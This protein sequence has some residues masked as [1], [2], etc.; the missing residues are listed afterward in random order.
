[1]LENLEFYFVQNILIYIK[2]NIL[3]N[4]QIQKNSC[5]LSKKV[6]DSLLHKKILTLKNP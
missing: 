4:Y 6:A 1:M 5:F 3:Q 2:N